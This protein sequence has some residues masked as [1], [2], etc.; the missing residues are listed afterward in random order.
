VPVLVDVSSRIRRCIC[1]FVISNDLWLE[2]IIRKCLRADFRTVLLKS[3]CSSPESYPGYV[4]DA[5]VHPGK[6][7][8]QWKYCFTHSESRQWMETNGWIVSGP[9]RFI[10]KGV[11]SRAV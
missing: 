1:S 2:V 10:Q 8:E 5:N 6:A 11:M 3:S 9:V 4:K 7:C